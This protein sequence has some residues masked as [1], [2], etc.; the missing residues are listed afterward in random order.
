MS[1]EVPQIPQQPNVEEQTRI[2]DWATESPDLLA[3]PDGADP[4]SAVDPEAGTSIPVTTEAT[5]EAT[6]TPVKKSDMLSLAELTQSKS[7]LNAIEQ[8]EL[9][10]SL[11]LKRNFSMTG[12]EHAE[13]QD[14]AVEAGKVRLEAKLKAHEDVLERARTK[15]NET[16]RKAHAVT[17]GKEWTAQQRS[18]TESHTQ[19]GRNRADVIARHIA[20]DRIHNGDVRF[21]KGEA[22]GKLHEQKVRDEAIAEADKQFPLPAGRVAEITPSGRKQ[23]AEERQ[24]DYA[25]QLRE[26]DKNAGEAATERIETKPQPTTQ[27]QPE[28]APRQATR[29]R[30]P[31]A[32]KSRAIK[33]QELAAARHEYVRIVVGRNRRTFHVDKEYSNASLWQASKRYQEARKNLRSSEQNLVDDERSPEDALLA[34]NTAAFAANTELIT[35]IYEQNLLTA[36][37]QPIRQRDGNIAEPKADADRFYQWWGNT[38]GKLLSI[39][40]LKK[41]FKIAVR[42]GPIGATRVTKKFMGVRLYRE[43]SEFTLAGEQHNALIDA[44]QLHGESKEHSAADFDITALINAQTEENVRL[45]R[46]RALGAAALAG[47]VLVGAG[48]GLGIDQLIGGHIHIVG[49]NPHAVE[50]ARHAVSGTRHQRG[51]TAPKHPSHPSSS[52]TPGASQGSSSST[53]GTGAGTSSAEFS[54]PVTPG[55]GVL[56]NL[57]ELGLNTSQAQE[58]FDKMSAQGLFDGHHIAGI[59]PHIPGLGEGP[60]LYTRGNGHGFIDYNNPIARHIIE[61][62]RKKASKS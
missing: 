32:E 49:N 26:F 12:K 25:A 13:A 34:A 31:E 56:Q 20:K 61:E 35:S 42:G 10:D 17:E 47:V 33:L 55:S 36:G 45:A 1:V 38:N 48:L 58:A 37:A 40:T 50:H 21:M 2:Y 39:A 62:A 22:V 60:T 44:A 29:V 41:A 57:H 46:R 43:G 54:A 59:G 51:S 18:Y 19:L 30:N 23:R 5:V 52:S 16:S 11:K 8:G 24:N 53:S 3:S 28:K 9:P 15:Y 4:N 7:D 6:P 14:A 27:A